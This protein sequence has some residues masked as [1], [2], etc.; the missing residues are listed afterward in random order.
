M[1]SLGL[2]RMDSVSTLHA[3]NG[4]FVNTSL[5]WGGGV[6]NKSADSWEQTHFPFTIQMFIKK[7]E[8]LNLATSKHFKSSDDIFI[9]L[10]DTLNVDEIL[11]ISYILNSLFKKGNV[12]MFL[13][14]PCS[15]RKVWDGL[16]K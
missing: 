15:Q 13:L 1:F 12:A 3:D 16:L 2:G 11:V 5:C 9:E 8:L 7:D 14:P 6:V 10:L 4:Q